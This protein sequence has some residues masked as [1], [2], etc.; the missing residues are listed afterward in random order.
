MSEE[1]TPLSQTL[2]ALFHEAPLQTLEQNVDRALK[3]ICHHLDCDA[4]FVL[5]GEP[6]T[7]SQKLYF[8]PLAP[9]TNGSDWALAGFPLFRRLLRT[10]QLLSC[11]DIC[12]LPSHAKAEKQFLQYQGVQSLVLLPALAFGQSRIAVGAVCCRPRT[13]DRHFMAE[14]HHAQALIGAAMELT[15]IAGALLDSERHYQDLFNQLPLA[16]GV[17]DNNNQL[18]MLNATA[19]ANLP[20]EETK[21]LFT[22]LSPEQHGMLQETLSVVRDGVLP[23]AFCEL[24]V[25]GRR[26]NSHWMKFTFSPMADSGNLVFVAENTDEQH[27]L[28]NELSFQ[29]NYDALTGLPNR[30]CFEAIL[31]RLVQQPGPA[32]V[33]IA[34][35]DLDQFQVINDVSGHIAGDKLLCL[36]AIRLQQLVRKGDIVARI[37]GDEF[38]IVM[39]H[40]NPDSA[41][42]IA[43][44]ICHQLAAYEFNWQGREHSVSASIGLAAVPD[45]TPNI[46]TVMSQADAACHL[47]KEQ[48]RNGWHY[49]DRQDPNMSRLYTE[50]LASVDILSALSRN[51]FELYFQLIEPLNKARDGLHM[52]ILL[53][54]PRDNG[55]M[56]SPAIFL[57]AAERYNLAARIDR[58]V[59][60]HLL[61]WAAEHPTQWQQM[62]MVSVNLSATSLA[63]DD[64]MTWLE[65]K[66]MSEPE[67]VDRLCF[68]ITE[69]AAV[70]Q[71]ELAQR[72][73]DMLKPL[74]CKLALDD[75]GS[76][77][78]S[79][80]YLKELDVDFVK[81]DGQF[82]SQLCDND[83]DK[84][85]VNS[86]C[87]LGQNM[88][89]ETIAEFVETEAIGRELQ[90]IGVTYGQG[91]SYDRPSALSQLES[92]LKQ[93]RSAG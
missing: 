91:Y 42:V 20:G 19:K 82:I 34:F 50:M 80:A 7:P 28:A 85:I 64:F 10:P 33:C 73:C 35:L 14:L 90:A 44:R 71:L 76:G 32:P 40:C 69:T 66:L 86:I 78:S 77:F 53:R 56:L 29:A 81:I 22:R 21:D 52:E 12:L 25:A 30:Q 9:L 68:E 45:D 47:A 11:S 15:R 54:L 18:T 38:A 8:H 74:G 17:L 61:A 1:H 4:V 59:V 13:W 36:L 75:F 65:L 23:Q 88:A 70:R 92:E 37:G 39:H 58:W 41:R 6:L 24:P 43:G 89:F 2:V 26:Q 5:G 93:V 79:F 84:A 57:P 67:L 48:G 83:K 55:E 87:Q 72:L 62:A 16:C 63:D 3:I 49:Y 31:T 27:R 46:Y 51:Q 60:D